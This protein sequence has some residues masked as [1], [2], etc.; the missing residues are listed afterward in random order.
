MRA[1]ALAEDFEDEAGAVDDLGMPAAFEVALLNRAEGSVDDDQTDCVVG[2]DF[3]QLLDIAAAEQCRRYRTVDA[4]AL[5]AHDLQVDRTR[6]SDRLV[7]TRLQRAPRHLRA[8][9]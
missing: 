3:A 6:Q 9:G 5:G 8:A 7:E 1:G 2:D 4:H